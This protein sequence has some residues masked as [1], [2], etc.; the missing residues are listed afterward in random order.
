MSVIVHREGGGEI[1]YTTIIVCSTEMV[2]RRTA[3]EGKAL[4]CDCEWCEELRDWEEEGKV[5]RA[6]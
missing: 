3:I 4:V 5:K 2:Y 6:R 1:R